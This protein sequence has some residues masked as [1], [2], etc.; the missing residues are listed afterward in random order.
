MGSRTELNEKLVEILGSRNVYFDPPSNTKM[1]YPAIE[2]HYSKFKS[3]RADNI[4][5]LLST[6]Y[7][8]TLIEYTPD[9]ETV[10]KL[11]LL[12]YCTH[13]RSF[14]SDNMHHH[15]FTIYY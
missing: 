14:V 2:Y 10:R 9:S 8:V 11:L 4:A 13:D 3:V 7:D 5:Y 6:S 1:H 15:T 12:P